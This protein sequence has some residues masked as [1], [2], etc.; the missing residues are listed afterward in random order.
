MGKK[1]NKNRS[2]KKTKQTMNNQYPDIDIFDYTFDDYFNSFDINNPDIFSS[3]FGTDFDNIQSF[4]CIDSHL[5]GGLRGKHTFGIQN[6]E[7]KEFI[8]KTLY[9]KVDKD[10]YKIFK[11]RLDF[12]LSCMQQLKDI[13][14]K[15]EG[16]WVSEF[17]SNIKY[18]IGINVTYKNYELLAISDNKELDKYI[19]ELDRL[20]I[21][22]ETTLQLTEGIINIANKK[23]K[24][25][26][27]DRVVGTQILIRD[28]SIINYLI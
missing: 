7:E 3:T 25:F 27:L 6:E 20:G 19:K 23:P 1:K 2:K 21:K 8:T 10:T 24:A 16:L 17:C 13:A 26:I 22:H 18:S 15:S 9:L 11:K 5:G 28:Y 4:G 12:N 14:E